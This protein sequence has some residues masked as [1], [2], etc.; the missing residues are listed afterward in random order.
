MSDW[1]Q[2]LTDLFRAQLYDEPAGDRLF[3]P[4][5]DTDAHDAPGATARRRANLEAAVEAVAC[6]APG[7]RP[8]VLVVAE[9]P[10]PWGCR[11][12]GIPFTNE[13]QL[14]DPDFPVEG[15]P[16]SARF[17]QSGEPVR[18]MSGGIYWDAM[19]PH[20][21]R[22]WTWNAVPFHPHRADEPLTI[23]TPGVRE[24]RRWHGLLADVIG[25]LAP[26]AVL[27]V[28]R[29]AEGAL[30]AVGAEP[31]YVRHPSQGGATLFRDGVAEFWRERGE[32]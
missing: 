23:R 29:K 1:R 24:V 32:R 18:E 15:R 3:N 10:G 17:A 4:Y 21:G 8:D 27:A 14:L 16:S 5:L 25:V 28:G 9:A 13:R 7:G 31:V 22:F 11:F 6:A 12:S 26:E 30:A 2:P 19:L 20:W